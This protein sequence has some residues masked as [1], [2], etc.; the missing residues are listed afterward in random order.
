MVKSLEVYIKIKIDFTILQRSL[1]WWSKF[2]LTAAI[3][4]LTNMNFCLDCT[5]SWI[6]KDIKF[7]P[8]YIFFI[9]VNVLPFNWFFLLYTLSV[10][11]NAN[12]SLSVYSFLLIYILCWRDWGMK[13]TKKIFNLFLLSKREFKKNCCYCVSPQSRKFWC[14]NDDVLAVPW[15]MLIWEKG[16]LSMCIAWAIKLIINSKCLFNGNKYQEWMRHGTDE[17][18]IEK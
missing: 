3:S 8:F 5:L 16:T 15:S 2:W 11:M 1:V 4:R 12:F 17:I 7:L 13:I 14:D 18:C 6:T 10:S 9:I